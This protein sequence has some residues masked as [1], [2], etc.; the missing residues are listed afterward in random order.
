MRLAPEGYPFIGIFSALTI[1]AVFVLGPPAA[2][3]PLVLALFMVYFFRDP[4]R[5][6]PPGPGFLSAADG[7]VIGVGPVSEAVHMEGPATKISV[8]MSAFN[9]HVNR[10]PC[11][12]EVLSVTRTPGRFLAAFREEASER[13][14]NVAMLL[15]CGEYQ[16][17]VRQVAGVMARRAVNRTKPGDRLGR[18]ERFGIIKFSSRLDHYFP[19]GVRVRVKP[20]E[21]VKAGLTVL[22]VLPEAQ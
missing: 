16:V 7:T 6:P 21:K 5:T 10:C 4:E 1:V 3:L 14:E 19:P 15:R 13:N 18:G 2:L 12:G 20:G 22:A 11:D 17:M 9:V 8:F